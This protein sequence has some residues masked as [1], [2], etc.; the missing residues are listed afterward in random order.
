MEN[1]RKAARRDEVERN[2]RALLHAAR[3][4]VD[5]DGAHASVAAIAARAGVGVGTLY[6]R[7][8]TKEQ[9]FQHLCTITL[10]DYLRAA[11][12]GLGHDD[13]WDG[14][15]HYIEQAVLA[16]TGAFGAIAGTIEVTAE[17]NELSTRGD[18]AAEELVRRAHQA[19]VLRADVGAVDVA[20]LIEQLGRSPLVE[21]IGR[22]GRAE[23]VE[24]AEHAR[25]RLISIAVD[26][27]RAPGGAPLAEPRPGW[28][29]FT[30]RW[31][32]PGAGL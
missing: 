12:E 14:L 15:A 22:Q 8:R 4:V 10:T 25:R 13:L 17:M 19:G 18:D 16:G 23:L 29:L 3:A 7:Y 1:R 26:G 31:T 5:E 32:S 28:E 2:N 24:A 30:E 9:L 21:T 6:R 27:L 11:E 20:L